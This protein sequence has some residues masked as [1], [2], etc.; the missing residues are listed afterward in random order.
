MAWK[1]KK[2]TGKISGIYVGKI[3]RQES[4]E[5]MDNEIKSRS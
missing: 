5:N 4:V 2:E 1:K 3:Q